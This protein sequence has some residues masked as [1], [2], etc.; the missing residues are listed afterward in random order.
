MYNFKLG[1]LSARNLHCFYTG[2]TA[3]NDMSL[4][5]FVYVSML[6]YSDNSSPVPVSN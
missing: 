4:Y 5:C 2:T 6:L 1:L 3:E